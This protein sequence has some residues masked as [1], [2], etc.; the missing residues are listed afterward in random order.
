MQIPAHHG[1]HGKE[2]VFYAKD[3]GKQATGMYKEVAFPQFTFYKEDFGSCV[4]TL[5]E[6]GVRSVV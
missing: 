5:L 2:L 6:V 1:G 4:S 3:N